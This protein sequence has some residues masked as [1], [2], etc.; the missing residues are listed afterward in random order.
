MTY[1]EIHDLATRDLKIDPLDIA[2]ESLRTQ[3]MI[4]RYLD[5]YRGEK[6]LQHLM[7]SEYNKLLAKKWEYFLG[8]A[9]DEVYLEK[10]FDKKVLR[11]DVDIYLNADEELIAANHKIN[12][13]KEKIFYLEKVIKGVE[14]REYSIKNAI[15]M[16]KFNAGEA[17]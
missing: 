17:S 15:T 16:I 6:M 12:L 9:P 14:Q 13:Q 11:Q 7:N 10:P 3:A 8:K 2:N 4:A 5:I 1:K